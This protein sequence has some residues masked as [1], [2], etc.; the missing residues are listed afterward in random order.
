MVL[1]YEDICLRVDSKRYCKD[2]KILGGE[3]NGHWWRKEGHRVDVEDLRDLLSGEPDII[4][5]GT[6]YAGLMEVSERLR[7]VLTDRNIELIE[8]VTP[9]AVKVFNKI[10]SRARKIAGAFHLT[11]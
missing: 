10:Q 5:I 4:V 7:R 2:L 6:G 11:C 3:V 9:E 1:Q 8:E